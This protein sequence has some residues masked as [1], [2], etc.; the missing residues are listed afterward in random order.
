M[1]PIFLGM[2]GLKQLTRIDAYIPPAYPW[3]FGGECSEKMRI[4]VDRLQ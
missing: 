4:G 3:V 1:S 2:D